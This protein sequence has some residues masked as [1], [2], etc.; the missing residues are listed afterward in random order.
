MTFASRA[1]GWINEIL[2]DQ[3]IPFDRADVEILDPARKRGDIV[4]WE[5][6]RTKRALLIEVKRPYDD[7]WGEVLDDALGKAWKN[8]IP[9]F[10]TWNVQRLFSWETFL[11]GDIMDKMWFPHAGISE[12]V[13]PVKS[14]EEM[15][16]YEE[17]IKR[18][19]LIFLKEFADVYFGVKPKPSLAVDERF[20]YRLRATMDALAIPI[21]EAMKDRFKKDRRF[22]S[23]LR[24]FFHQQAWTFSGSDED[25]ERVSRQYVHLFTDKI[26]FYNVLVYQRNLPKIDVSGAS[27][28]AELKEALQQYFKKATDIDYQTIFSADFLDSIDPPEE[29]VSALKGF[30]HRISEHDF[31]KIGFEVL[32]RIFER[33]I[34]EWERHKLGQYFTRTD[35]VD[36]IVGF[37][38]T[39]PD[40]KVLDGAVGAGTFLVRTY[41]RKKYLDSKRPHRRIMDDLFGMDIAKFPSH[42]S[43]I[44]LA[45][46]DLWE[47]E[48]YPRILLV[49]FFDTKPEQETMLMPHKYVTE[50]LSEKKLRIKLPHMD[51]V[52]MNPPYTRQEE[53]ED[54][55]EG[56]KE[57]AHSI[58]TEEWRR[59]SKN[60]YDNIQPDISK[61][62]SIYSYFFI[63]GGYFLKEG[64]RMGLITS[65]AWLDVDYGKDLQRFFL[66]NFKIIAI[67]ASKVERWFEDADINT[68]ITIV[69]KCDGEKERRSNVVKFVQLKRPLSDLVRMDGEET[70]WR[71][72][73]ELIRKIVGLDE[74][75][76]DDRIK[77][78]PQRQGGLWDEG[79]DDD[80]QDYVGAQW[81]KYV[82]APLIFF[83][84]LRKGRGMIAPLRQIGEVRYP[85][86]TGINDFFYVEQDTIKRFG[87][88]N[89]FLFPIVK[90]S[91]EFDRILLHTASL[92][93][94]LFSCGLSKNALAKSG[95]RGAL[96]YIEW[97]EKQVTG[98]RQKTP[99]G[100]PWP[101]VP[102]VKGR[103]YWYFI[104]EIAPADL[105][106]NRFFDRR[107]FFGFSR[108]PVIE[109]Q[110]FYGLTYDLPNSLLKRAQTAVLNS[111]LMAM[112]VE[113][114]GQVS[115]GQGVLQYSKDQMASLI[116]ID[117]RK[118]PERTNT[119]LG[120]ALDGISNNSLGTVFEEI[121]A[122]SPELV[123]LH[124][125]KPDR[126]KLD[127]IVMGEILGLTEEEESDVYRAVIDLVRSRVERS[128]S[129][130]KKKVKGAPDIDALIESVAQEATREL[131]FNRLKTFPEDYIGGAEHTT[132]EVPEGEVQSGSDLSGSYVMINRKKIRCS[133]AHEARYIEL[134]VLNGKTHI[135]I[136]KDGS[137]V[138]DAVRE[139]TRTVKQAKALIAELVQSSITDKKT[140]ETVEERVWKKLSG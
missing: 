139:H 124:K 19:L 9:Y 22:G 130:K 108:K 134:A 121:G 89:E 24:S 99:A 37:C 137:I 136:P 40:D 59:L 1:A 138:K 86:K 127:G 98:P 82:R 125:V 112:F 70:R 85:I 93:K 77:V 8:D 30:T 100:V 13:A 113:L 53:M 63:H 49:D 58:C 43:T 50:G 25:F 51:A 119:K 91:K 83:T 107:F 102:S 74:Y 123:S 92:K 18:F 126:R 31:S 21:F 39:K 128:K 120:E 2:K 69:E 97:G 29:I 105:V 73:D 56:E 44:N 4:L 17:A 80:E 28:A 55:I 72:V 96:R 35:V 81:G 88:E 76:E 54:I 6:R 115:L 38:V 101:R 15:D 140:R 60:K 23:E 5:K 66:E 111:T 48:S 84:T 109:D 95:K 52:V 106:C 129:V 10:A 26:V 7:P 27:S 118:V 64:G 47:V 41:Y 3:D 75:H 78:C 116:T 103:E 90:T 62:S 94:F 34:P 14:L 110:T 104:P 46:R 65:N 42:L 45:I 12:V 11:Q 16:R 135:K 122:D 114:H 131:G 33:L 79:Y 71:S 133:S 61:R 67:I 117:V 36:L 32:G 57:K 20:I 132:I 68:V 87:I